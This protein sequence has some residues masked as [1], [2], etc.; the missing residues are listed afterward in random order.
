[1]KWVWALVVLVVLSLGGAFLIRENMRRVSQRQ[2][3]EA[4]AR[5]LAEMRAAIMKY[6]KETGHYPASLN[7]LVPQ[8][9]RRIPPDPFTHQVNW[10]VT[11]EETVTPSED[12]T[13]AAAA[14]AQSV[15]IDVHSSAPGRDQN[16]RA[17][18]DY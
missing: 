10:R 9:I 12:F 1:M 16:G 2:T 11:T 14:P 18:S 4:L 7:D 6:H 5:S 13:T 15:I 17:Y 8:Y 3:A